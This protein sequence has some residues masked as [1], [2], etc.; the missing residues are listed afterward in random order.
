MIMFRR[1]SRIERLLDWFTSF[2]QNLRSWLRMV[3]K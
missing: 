3:R 1:K 2:Y